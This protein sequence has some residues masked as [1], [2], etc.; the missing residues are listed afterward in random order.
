M[1]DIKAL[2]QNPEPFRRSLQ[3]RGVDT[4]ILD[5]IIVANRDR[6]MAAMD[7]ETKRSEQNK[8]GQEIARRKR[9][10]ESA[11]AL[12]AEMQSLSDRIKSDQDRLAQL[13]GRVRELALV[14]PNV[15]H[16]S[17]PEGR[18][19]EHNQV[20][21]VVGE[22]KKFSF[23]PLDHAD[24]GE[25]LGLLDF[26]R[27][28]KMTGA[29][30]AVLRGALAQLER[31][32]IQ[33]MV[34]THVRE[35][36]YQEMLPPFIVN[37]AS[38]EGTGQFPKFRQ[39][40][41]RLEGFDMYLVPTAE[42]PL[43][44]FYAGEIL[45]EEALPTSFAAYTP[46]FRSEA[47]SYGRDTKGLIRQHQFNKVELMKFTRPEESYEEHEKLTS[48]AEGI[49]KRLELPYRVVSLCA[50]D[51][52]FGAAKCY[53]LEV[54]LPGQGGYREISS[55]SNFEDFQARRAEIRYRPKDKGKPRY[56]HT[57]NGSGLAV[58][59]TLIAILENYQ[60]EDGT[61]EVPNVLRGYMN[62]RVTIG[63]A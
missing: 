1:L 12:V 36:G 9:A 34:D 15:L 40:V 2:E 56:V 38:L 61:V 62:E 41:F 24:I 19:T 58:G 44:N 14:V 48:H 5:E 60:R 27:A 32:L 23:Q 25:R 57:L 17:V 45:E 3:L 26:A 31:A 42:V 10:G 7:F 18:S 13:E 52:G 47:G 33:F 49:L 30:F 20:V 29:R 46:C 59:R 43:T 4:A 63:S 37:A 51:I 16:P 53:D 6:K 11:D 39:D 55:C 54:W 22:A 35:N 50:G 28:G 21:R 8:I